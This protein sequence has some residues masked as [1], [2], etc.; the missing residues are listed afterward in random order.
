MVMSQDKHAGQDHNIQG[1]NK[2]FERVEQFE[3]FGTTLIDQS[4]IQEKTDSRLKSECYHVVQN[5][6]S[7]SYT[8]TPLLAFMACSSMNFLWKNLYYVVKTKSSTLVPHLLVYIS[9][10][11]YH[12][13]STFCHTYTHSCTQ[14]VCLKQIM[15]QNNYSF[16]CKLT[17]IQGCNTQ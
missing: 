4:S 11:K 10:Q 15:C 17:R 2:S 8:S 14:I 13:F 9:L 16:I 7:S 3:Y 1:G 12:S 5:L 6:L